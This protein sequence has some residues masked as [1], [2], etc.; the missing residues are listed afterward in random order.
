[1]D[2]PIARSLAIPRVI[3]DP[4]R[5]H[6]VE[7]G[8]WRT[9]TDCYEFLAQNVTP[10]SRTLETGLGISTGLFAVWGTEHTC[11]VPDPDEVAAVRGWAGER[12]I[13]LG[14]MTFAV[15]PSDEILPRLEPTELDLV[16]VD[17]AHNWPLP[18]I[19]WYYAAGRLRE[20]GV[21]VFDDIQLP[22]VRL[23]LFDFL[24][25]DPRWEPVARTNKW[26][27]CVRHASGPIHE[28]HTHQTFLGA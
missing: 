17:G 9:D 19:D 11:V 1:M 4:P 21:V 18:I 2:D 14:R 23:G 26:A 3:K 12:D 15:G 22:H 13:D 27:A 24:Q 6:P 16:F 25:A 7:G 5:P 28:G 10:A 8:V 20:G